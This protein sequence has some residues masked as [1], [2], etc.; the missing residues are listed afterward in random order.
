M[1]AVV[2]TVASLK[3][4]T[5]NRNKGGADSQN[6]LIRLTSNSTLAPSL[7]PAWFPLDSLLS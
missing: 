6:S 1:A 5:M 2:V 3:R 7:Y 4:A